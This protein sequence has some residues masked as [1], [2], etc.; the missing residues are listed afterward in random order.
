MLQC[1]PRYRRSLLQLA[2]QLLFFFFFFFT[3]YQLLCPDPGLC[4]SSRQHNGRSIDPAQTEEFHPLH[5]LMPPCSLSNGQHLMV[6]STSMGLPFGELHNGF[7]AAGQSRRVGNK[8]TV[9]MTSPYR[10]RFYA[11]QLF[12]SAHLPKPRP[13]LHLSWKMK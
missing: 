11:A 13:A 5:F 2:F 6:I 9:M 7:T 12:L 8:S 3:F 4:A 10:W 1:W